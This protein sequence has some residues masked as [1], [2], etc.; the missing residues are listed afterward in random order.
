MVP[1]LQNLGNTCFMNSA[2]QCLLNCEALT[3]YFLGFDWKSEIN[4][5]NFLGHKGL[6]ASAF[7]A[8][9]NEMWRSD[10][11]FIRPAGFKTQ[12]S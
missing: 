11:A 6:M 12:V 2:L 7:G 8:L 4:T 9:A 3:D 5:A 1:G 10:R